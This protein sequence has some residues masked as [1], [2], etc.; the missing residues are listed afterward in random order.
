MNERTYRNPTYALVRTLKMLLEQPDVEVRGHKTKEVIGHSMKFARPEE[1]FFVL[2]VRNGNP[3][4]VVAE[5]LWVLAG[6]N[7]ITWLKRY[8]P[9]APKFS[10]DGQTWR[11]GYGPRLRFWGCTG[12]PGD[13]YD[14]HVLAWRSHGA[15]QITKVLEHLRKDLFTRQAVISL[16]DPGLDWCVSKDIPCNN[17]LQFIWRQGMLHLNVTVRSNDAIFG[18]SHADV[19]IWSLL[20]EAMAYWLREWAHLETYSQV[21]VGTMTWWVGSY[22]V[23]ERHYSK[24]QEIV[25]NFPGHTI[26]DKWN[27]TPV[28][29][30]TKFAKFDDA[31]IQWFKWEMLMRDHPDDSER[32]LME[33]TKTW[34]RKNT[35][36]LVCLA[37]MHIYNMVLQKENRLEICDHIYRYLPHNS[38]FYYTA[39]EYVNRSHIS[40]D[41]SFLNQLLKKF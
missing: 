30:D 39:L 38:D 21:E 34:G 18:F 35:F 3:F 25:R 19:F 20:Q 4:A 23:Y 1:R 41:H 11:A 12:V 24:A 8:I 22:H 36:L 28:H 17:W 5:A 2:P 6:R 37:M 14:E 9:M 10:D 15:C 16:W 27:L 31:L 7:D 26:Y 40:P 33:A 29:F 13:V 32:I